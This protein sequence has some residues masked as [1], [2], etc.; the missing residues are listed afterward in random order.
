M[1]I[2]PGSASGSETVSS[3][4]TVFAA[5]NTWWPSTPTKSPRCGRSYGVEATVIGSIAPYLPERIEPPYSPPT[6]VWLGGLR[7]LKRPELFL[8]MA[9]HFPKARFVMMG[10]PVGSDTDC[11]AKTE[12]EA[13][14]LSNVE[15]LGLTADPSPR[16]ARAWV[17][18]NTSVLEGYPSSFL[19][20]WGHGV[21]TV[22]FVD[23]GGTVR[24]EGLGRV[25]EDPR[26]LAQVL[27]EVLDSAAL[28]N[29]LG[30]RARPY[31]EREHGCGCGGRS[32]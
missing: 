14:T 11:Y 2:D 28:R 19:E 22:S 21:P 29:E 3:T 23:P 30:A 16:L 20:A 25:V 7:T 15:F 12:A 27:G 9:R 13:R 17:L 5:L 1:P 31:V 8:A 24:K 6:V 26:Q 10:G 32:L 18:L 4:G